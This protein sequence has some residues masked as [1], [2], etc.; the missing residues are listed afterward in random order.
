MQ[1]NHINNIA[2]IYNC[3]PGKKGEWQYARA[4]EFCMCLCVGIYVGFFY[5]LSLGYFD[6]IKPKHVA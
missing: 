3:V 1:L 5:P 2:K 6:F 4:T